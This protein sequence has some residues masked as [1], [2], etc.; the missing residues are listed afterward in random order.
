MCRVL[1]I[2][3]DF[4]RE[5]EQ[6]IP[7]STGVIK[8]YIE[9]YS[10]NCKVDLLSID[11]QHDPLP[12]WLITK[13]LA[14]L[15]I[16]YDFI[17]ISAFIWSVDYVK[18]L[19]R[20]LRNEKKYYNP[21]I[22]GGA[23]ITYLS[24]KELISEFPQADFFVKG[25]GEQA[26]LDIITGKKNSRIVRS[27]NKFPIPPVYSNR[28]IPIAPKIR[29]ET[30]RG[31]PYNCSFCAFKDKG[32]SKVN[33]IPFSTIEREFI[34]LNNKVLK[35][36]LTDP[37]FNIKDYLSIL[38]FLVDIH[39]TPLIALQ[40]RF[41]LIRGEKGEKFLNLIQQL[42]VY[43]EFGLQTA[44]EH[45]AKLINRR[46]NIQHVKD[47]IKELNQRKIKYK[48]DL[49]YGLPEQT[50]AS[51]IYSINFL[52]SNGCNTIAA[53]PLAIYPG[54]QLADELDKFG[55]KM[56]TVEFGIK[57]VVESNTFSYQDYLKMSEIAQQ[58]NAEFEMDKNL[59]L[60]KIINLPTSVKQAV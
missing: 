18:E 37:I 11:I 25:F 22:L 10:D 48:V 29:T 30:K 21:I 57:Q 59:E 56:Q 2:S 39:F 35:V 38:E 17:G 46:N 5:Y 36:N 34:F 51:F 55:M 27:L 52:K 43:L 47:V 40:T 50:L 49:I 23:Q 44:V 24:E 8:S 58:L 45:E 3:F 31:C 6:K 4:H 14:H 53:F 28:T 26:F 12:Q 41:E 60:Q 1:L 19:L 42:N 7:Y 13:E 32:S 54:T 33:E 9:K 16:D 15:N 20:Y